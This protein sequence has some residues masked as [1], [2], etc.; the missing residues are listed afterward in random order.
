MIPWATAL[1]DFGDQLLSGL[2]TFTDFC[3]EFA[4]EHRILDLLFFTGALLIRS[5]I[6]KSG[7]FFWPTL[8]GEKEFEIE[9]QV[10]VAALL[11]DLEKEFSLWT[12]LALGNLDGCV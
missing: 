3:V 2:L 5:V 7:L 4:F 11:G 8:E 1:S 10:V 9:D 12:S 6:P